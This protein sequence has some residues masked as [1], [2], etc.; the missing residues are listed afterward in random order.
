VN[1]T[2]FHHHSIYHKNNSGD[3]LTNTL[4]ANK[5]IVKIKIIKES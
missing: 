3:N 1:T 4:V 5:Y 2:I